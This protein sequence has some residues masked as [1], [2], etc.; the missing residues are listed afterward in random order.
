[1]QLNEA[2]SRRII[3]LCNK[4]NLSIHGLSIK[5]GVAN[6]TLTDIIK[7]KHNS[8]QLKFIFSLCDGLN[9]SLAEFFSSA[10]FDKDT[11]TD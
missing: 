5:A 7:T 2:V 3:E 1:M 8:T 9:I 10:Y 6:S 11:L 4:E